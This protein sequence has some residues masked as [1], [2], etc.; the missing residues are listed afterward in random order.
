MKFSKKLLLRTALVI[1]LGS[2]ASAQVII[3]ESTVPVAPERVAPTNPATVRPPVNSAEI[4]NP[5]AAVRGNTF[6]GMD[7]RNGTGEKIAEV[8]DVVLDARNGKM[9]YTAISCGEVLGLGGKLFAVPWDATEMRYDR[10]RKEY[11]LFMRA[12]QADL[13]RAPGFDRD[14]WPN[15]ADERWTSEVD[16][17]YLKYRVIKQP[18]L[19][20]EPQGQPVEVELDD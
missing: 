10:N 19:V 15:F 12:T 20:R 17:Y 5:A 6:D 3:E 8:E 7:V 2:T 4:D 14:R 18:V 13:A 11:F 1:A 16:K 9:R